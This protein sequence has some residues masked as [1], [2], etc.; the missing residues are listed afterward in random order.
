[1]GVSSNIMKSPSPESYM[2]LWEM[3]IYSDIL[4]WSDIQLNR[5]LV[6][7]LELITDCDSRRAICGSNCGMPAGNAYPSGHLVPSPI[8]WLAYDPLVRTSF[9]ELAVS[10]LDFSSLIPIGTFSI[11][12]PLQIIMTPYLSSVFASNSTCLD[13]FPFWKGIVHNSLRLLCFEK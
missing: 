2:T 6:T 7:E 8:L 5:D 10:F 1:M 3:T 13:T 9:S 4:N 12:R 11:S